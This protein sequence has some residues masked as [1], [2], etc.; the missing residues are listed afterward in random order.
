[1]DMWNAPSDF[2]LAVARGDFTYA[3][4]GEMEDEPPE[5]LPTDIDTTIPAV[6]NLNDEPD[7]F[8]IIY[9]APF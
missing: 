4:I 6:H 9:D 2:D 3:D 1:M 8:G 5:D 7:V